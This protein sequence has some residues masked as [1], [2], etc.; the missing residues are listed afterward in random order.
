MN[1]GYQRTPLFDT[2]F[3]VGLT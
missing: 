2:C 1:I 3:D